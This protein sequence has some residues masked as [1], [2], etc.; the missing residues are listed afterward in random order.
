[1]QHR[2]GELRD[3]LGSQRHQPVKV[4]IGKARQAHDGDGR[5]AHE[6]P[7]PLEEWIARNDLVVPVGCDEE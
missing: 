4:A 1:M 5:L 3:T 2:C 6:L 7:E